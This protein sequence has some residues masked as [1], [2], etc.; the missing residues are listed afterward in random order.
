MFV[1]FL[2]AHFSD[3]T[4]CVLVVLIEAFEIIAVADSKSISNLIIANWTVSTCA[5]FLRRC[6]LDRFYI[7]SAVC[8]HSIFYSNLF[9]SIARGNYVVSPRVVLRPARSG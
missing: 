4:T 7:F 2:Q 5:P 8:F 1:I 3:F 6:N 9:S